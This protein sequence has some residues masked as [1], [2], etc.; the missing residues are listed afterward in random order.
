MALAL[1]LALAVAVALAAAPVAEREPGLEL[2]LVREPAQ[3]LAQWWS[4]LP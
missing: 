2:G 3:G 4:A 1:A